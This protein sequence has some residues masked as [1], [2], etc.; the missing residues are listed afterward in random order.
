MLSNFVQS[1]LF[2][3]KHF[4]L[5]DI[6]VFI[7]FGVLI[8]LF[9]F[10]G[11]LLFKKSLILSFFILLLSTI[12]IFIAPFFIKKYINSATRTIKVELLS[13]KQLQYTDTFIIHANIANL[14]KK[15]LFTC[16]AYIYLY[17][18]L[19][20]KYAKHLSWIRSPL[21][22]KKDL[23]LSLQKAQNSDF[24]ITLDNTRLL[25]DTNLTIDAECY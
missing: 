13:T 4:E 14:S 9:Y 5:L 12:L 24:T 16:K 3:T 1:F 11:F 7:W 23:S 21:I 19:K 2:Y 10:L 6:I 15:D 20:N 25:K 8:V 22:I 17:T 18:P